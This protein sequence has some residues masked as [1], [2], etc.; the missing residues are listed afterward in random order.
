MNI[1]SSYIF[2]TATISLSTG[3]ALLSRYIKGLQPTVSVF[4][5]TA[6]LALFVKLSLNIDTLG[7]QEL[8]SSYIDSIYF[9]D[10]VVNWLLSYLLFAASLHICTKEF[11][12]YI[13][14][15]V[16]LAFLGTSIAIVSTATLTY[17]V[18]SLISPMSVLACLFF[19]TAISP[20]DPVAVLA[21]LKNIK[22]SKAISAKI[23]G[24]SLLNDG[25]G[26]VIFT[27]LTELATYNHQPSWLSIISFFVQEVAGGLLIGFVVAKLGLYAMQPHQAQD[28]TK[29]DII[30]TIGMINLTQCLALLTQVSPALSAV[31]LG[32]SV[33][34]SLQGISSKRTNDLMQFWDIIDEILNFILFFL[35]GLE[36]IR[37][38]MS[39][40]SIFL[41]LALVAIAITSIVR[42]LSV[43]IPMSV[44]SVWQKHSPH[45]VNVI[46]LGGIKGGLSLALISIMPNNVVGKDIVVFMVY[47]VVAFTIIVQTQLI[48]GYLIK[49]KKVLD[50]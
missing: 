35:I 27:I 1:E 8:I 16:L 39:Q 12:K 23:A 44:A 20:T 34:H 46:S 10:V 14:E 11:K 4:A 47:S 7:H 28:S 3:F 48:Q 26:I 45:I 33:G 24:E 13:R 9:H 49:I 17:L 22:V 29:M 6:I 40:Y 37:L 18:S 31:A 25:V 36:I 5:C 43:Y 30:G 2:L 32:L 21:L 38:D 42:Y 50:S 15:I 19:A 41:I